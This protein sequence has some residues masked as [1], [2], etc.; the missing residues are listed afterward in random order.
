MK[1]TTVGPSGCFVVERSQKLCV[2]G[3]AVLSGSANGAFSERKY[4]AVFENRNMVLL[5]HADTMGRK[6]VLSKIYFDLFYF[7]LEGQGECTK[8]RVASR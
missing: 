8:D 2:A 4:S 3:F 6:P 1:T 7:S 5:F